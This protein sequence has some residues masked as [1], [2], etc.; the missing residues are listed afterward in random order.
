MIA[1]E[2][3]PL[4]LWGVVVGMDL[5]T[6]PQIGLSRPLVAG[7]VAG[8]LLGDV[9]AGLMVGA[10]LELFALDVLPVGASKYPD[11]GLGAIA[12]ATVVANAPV[13]LAI[14]LAVFIGLTVAYIGGKGIHAVRTGN[15]ADAVARERDID[16][17]RASVINL[18]HARGM[19]RDAARAVAVT[20]IGI[21][22]A[23]FAR[24]LVHLSARAAV[25]ATLVALGAALASSIGGAV[26]VAGRT[27]GVRIY[28][29]GGTIG[30][31]WLV[32]R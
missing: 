16:S 9:R 21:G 24:N 30:L 23:L 32:I 1:T 15:T 11:Y 14:G 20:G 25:M 27:P 6:V 12:G 31:A 26:N 8:L 5:T 4:L 29:I 13:E 2:L 7:A 28:I 17:G 22:L 18:L 19:L 10:V 3:W